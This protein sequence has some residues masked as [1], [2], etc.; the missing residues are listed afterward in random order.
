MYDWYAAPNR[1]LWTSNTATTGF[2]NSFTRERSDTYG[3]SALMAVEVAVTRRVYV[4]GIIGRLA[5]FHSTKRKK[6]KEK[7]P[8]TSIL[9]TM[10]ESH[11]KYDPPPEMG[12]RRKMMPTD[13]AK[14]P[15]K[16]MRLILVF[17]PSLRALL[18]T[19]K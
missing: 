3:H 17:S 13:E 15:R 18:G 10:G 2:L 1:K 9:I 11:S 7:L 8:M 4:L 12:M 14:T 6:M 16:S 19:R 5:T